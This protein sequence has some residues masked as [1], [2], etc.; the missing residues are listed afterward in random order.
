MANSED[1]TSA[2]EEAVNLY[3]PLSH[4]V[5]IK[6]WKSYMSAYSEKFWEKVEFNN[7]FCDS[8]DNIV[9]NRSEPL[10]I[11]AFDEETKVFCCHKC[12]C[13]YMTLSCSKVRPTR[14]AIVSKSTIY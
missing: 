1:V 2:C 9:K 6:A 12:V 14:Y 4:S 7:I 13:R 11:C 10:F 8:C 5:S 3:I